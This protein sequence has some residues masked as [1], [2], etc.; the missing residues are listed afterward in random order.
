MNRTV[1]ASGCF[2]LLHAGHVR[3]LESAAAYGR[4]TVC[5]GT[6]ANVELLKGH[7]PH[8]SDGERTYML[9]ALDCVAEARLSSGTGQLDFEPD[10]MELRPDYF[11]VNEDG[12][13]PDKRALCEREGVEYI[14]LE[15]RPAPG[16][17]ERS[18]TVIKEDLAGSLPYRLCL[19]GGWLDQPWVSAIH[20]GPVITCQVAPH[21]Q[22]FERAGLATS[23]R[24][25][26]AQLTE[27][28][29]FGDDREELARVLFRYENAPGTP[30]VSGSQD[31]L[32]LTLGGIN[33]LDY[34]GHYWPHEISTISSVET[35][36]WLE[37]RLV[38][39]PLGP[40]PD[41]YD[42]LFEQHPHADAVAAL[43]N[44]A[45]RTWDG[46]QRHDLDALGEGLTGTHD[47]WRELLPNT[48]N[49]EID[50]RLAQLRSA[51]TGATT[52]GAGGGFAIIAT[53]SPPSDL[54]EN[55]F[56]IRLTT[57]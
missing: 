38:L 1:L 53:E 44:S 8:F 28:L 12:D 52:S 42:P 51:G 45:I 26:W 15:R 55:A 14:V 29:D 54:A 17:P 36:Q 2:D 57:R 23:T 46:I 10:L 19:A 33:R 27:Q 25:V 5:L 13:R 37:D 40:R 20:G 43:A 7:A 49:A 34:D 31:A 41:G 18:S 24:T 6:D 47:A 30:Y 22:F 3:F 50:F 21:P 48:T 56:H 4:L 11:V 16:L 32:G 35:M 39:V 9:G